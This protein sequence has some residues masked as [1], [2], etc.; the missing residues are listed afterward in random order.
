MRVWCYILVR[1]RRDNST[2][3]ASI[4]IISLTVE[5]TEDSAVVDARVEF[6]YD[7]TAEES[8]EEVVRVLAG[9]HNVG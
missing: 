3:G 1:R 4:V 2:N 9:R 8:L 6:D 5:T 7:R